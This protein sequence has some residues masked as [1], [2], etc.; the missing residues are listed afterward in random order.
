MIVDHGDE[1]TDRILAEAD[2]IADEPRLKRE[3]MDAVTSSTKDAGG[4]EGM[5]PCEGELRRGG[6]FARG[7]LLV[8]HFS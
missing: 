7:P 6:A 2:I 5:A 4:T 3:I 1:Q 8:F